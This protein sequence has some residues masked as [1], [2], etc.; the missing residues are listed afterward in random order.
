MHRSPCAI[1]MAHRTQKIDKNVRILKKE[2]DRT[3]RCAS[4][5]FKPIAYKLSVTN[6]K[7][8]YF[9]EKMTATL[10]SKQTL[11]AKVQNHLRILASFPTSLIFH[12][13]L[14]LTCKFP[15]S[16]RYFLSHRLLSENFAIVILGR[17]YLSILAMKLSSFGY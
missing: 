15:S 13:S 8:K 17:A 16:H 2:A 6:R 1:I 5:I 9:E 4:P 10:K 14:P 7:R 3:V 11:I 12:W